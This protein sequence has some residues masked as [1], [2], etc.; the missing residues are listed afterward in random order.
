MAESKA[1]EGRVAYREDDAESR[2]W[3]YHGTVLSGKLRVAVRSA[4]DREQGGVLFPFDNC[5]K[6]GS[7]VLE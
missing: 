2:G 4:M 5:T 1:R 3:R 6:T 7:P